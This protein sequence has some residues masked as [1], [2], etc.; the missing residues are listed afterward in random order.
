M[1]V[2]AQAGLTF[3][4]LLPNNATTPAFTLGGKAA[5]SAAVGVRDTPPTVNGHL[6]EATID[7]K[8]KSSAVGELGPLVISLLDVPMQ[9]VMNHIIMF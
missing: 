5:T 7:L 4:V 3:A 8:F 1:D 9:L 2:Q 6:N